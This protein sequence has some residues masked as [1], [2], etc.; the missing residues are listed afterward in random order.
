MRSIIILL[1]ILI[2]LQVILFAYII[3]DDKK[4]TE[5][6]QTISSNVWDIATQLEID[7]NY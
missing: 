7:L 2:V 4:D 6:R 3:Y 5:E 1:S